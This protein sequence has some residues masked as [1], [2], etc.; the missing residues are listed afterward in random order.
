MS[1]QLAFGKAIELARLRAGLSQ[2]ELARRARMS[3]PALS[4]RMSGRR[5][6]TTSDIDR[7]ADA[8]GIDPFDLM[9]TL[10]RH[11]NTFLNVWRVTDV[12]RDMMR[13][14]RIS[15]SQMA[16][17]TGIPLATLSRRLNRRGRTWMVPELAAVAE[18]LGTTL[19]GLVAQAEQRSA[20]GQTQRLD[21]RQALT[22]VLEDA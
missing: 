12:I 8:L 3:G 4:Q 16:E 15:Q 20:D 11:R 1:T 13:N 17:A 10:A 7:L 2:A 9:E 18:V 6:I 19:T 14:A 21:W 5:P 22:E